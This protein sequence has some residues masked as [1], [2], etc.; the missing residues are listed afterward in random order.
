[1]LMALSQSDFVPD[2]A[3]PTS[4]AVDVIF[5]VAAGLA[6]L[7]GVALSIRYFR[8]ERTPLGFVCMAGGA[9]ASLFEP[10]AAANGLVHYPRAGQVILFSAYGVDIP[11]FLTLAYT[12]EIGLGAL[13]TWRLLRAGRG[14]NAIARVWLLIALGDILLETPALWLHVFSYYGPQPLN[15]WGMPLY[16]APLDGALGI[17]PAV[18]IHL[19]HRPSWKLR[20]YL[21]TVAVFPSSVAIFYMGAGW[22]I[23]LLMHTGV[24]LPW[25]WL[26]A[27]ASIGLTYLFVRG[28]A[29][30]STLPRDTVDEVRAVTWSWRA[31]L[32][33]PTSTGGA[34]TT[35]PL[36]EGRP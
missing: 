8:R 9:V 23:F 22:P 29:A 33:T 30:L 34:L 11:L 17:L 13:A 28:L 12:A 21:V 6:V 36:P 3:G 5:T 1:V 27:L 7:V 2:P 19:L 35:T 26:A 31:A 10:I 32:W 4:P 14:P 25:I 15:L 18:L 20:Q 24:A 16:W